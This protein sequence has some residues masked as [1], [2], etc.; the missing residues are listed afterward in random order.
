MKKLKFVFVLL[1]LMIQLILPQEKQDK[2]QVDFK[3]IKGELT[4]KDLFKKD[5]GR[6][7]GFEIELY[8]G[9]AV[10]FVAYSN[11]FQPSIALVNSKGDIFKQSL[12]NDK[13]F[14]NI[15]AVIPSGGKW[16]MY[17]IGEENAKGSYTLQAAIAE[18]NS[19]LLNPNADFC[20]TL[21]FLISHANAYFF[22]LE[23]PR[24]AKQQLVKI[25]DAVDAYIDEENGSYNATFYSDNDLANAESMFL[26][27]TDKIKKCLGKNWQ[28]IY[29]NW[30]KIEDYKEKSITFTERGESKPRYVRI[31]IHDYYASKQNYENKIIVEIE[32]NKK[33]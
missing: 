5:F 20:T 12:R 3:E 6:Y 30:Q 26:N 9:E 23:S 1:L 4:S 11:N 15:E 2:F 32:I 19:L 28:V 10:N 31:T 14:A 24:L 13:G 33:H 21:D 29:R 18:P 22:L 27:V 8:E 17:L 16:V 7:D 25:N